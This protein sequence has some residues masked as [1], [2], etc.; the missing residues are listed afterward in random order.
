MSAIT[1]NNLV[2]QGQYDYDC[3]MQ[4]V[5]KKDAGGEVTLKDFGE[6]KNLA[7]G[8]DK[9]VIPPAEQNRATKEAVYK[10]ILARFGGEGSDD[11]YANPYIQTAFEFLLCGDDAPL[12]ADE[13]KCLDQLLNKGSAGKD[14]VKEGDVAND[15]KALRAL[16]WKSLDDGIQSAAK[17]LPKGDLTGEYVNALMEDLGKGFAEGIKPFL[18]E[19]PDNGSFADD[20]TADDLREDAAAYVADALLGSELGLKETLHGKGNLQVLVDAYDSNAKALQKALSAQ[21]N[22]KAR[23]LEFKAK[24]LGLIIGAAPKDDKPKPRVFNLVLDKMTKQC[25]AVEQVK[26]DKPKSE[27]VKLQVNVAQPKVN[28]VQQVNVAQQ[29]VKE[30]KPVK[31]DNPVNQVKSAP[32]VQVKD[33]LDLVNSEPMWQTGCSNCCWFFSAVNALKCMEGGLAHLKELVKDDRVVTFY[34]KDNVAHKYDLTKEDFGDA[35]FDVEEI[36]KW[37]DKGCTRLE[38]CVMC[39]AKKYGPKADYKI[40]DSGDMESACKMLGLKGANSGEALDKN[41]ELGDVRQL[42]KERLVKKQVVT[43]NAGGGHF[44]SIVGIDDDKVTI[45][46]SYKGEQNQKK[47][48]RQT[49]SLSYLLELC[50]KNGIDKASSLY[51]MMLPKTMEKGIMRIKEKTATI[52]KDEALSFLR[53]RKN[54]YE[55]SY[56]EYATGARGKDLISTELEKA[57]TEVAKKSKL[58]E[59][60]IEKVAREEN[61]FADL[62]KEFLT[63][64]DT[65]KGQQDA[66]AWIVNGH[67]DTD[68]VIYIA[69]PRDFGE[70]VLEDYYSKE[71]DS[72]KLSDDTV[73]LI[74][75][76]VKN[77]EPDDEKL[78]IKQ[79]KNKV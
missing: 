74:A 1:N 30:E 27:V 66:G 20:V 75:A 48:I 65:P 79:K 47:D 12:K 64:L 60:L 58:A 44:I 5:G 62:Q 37:S 17:K 26:V 23:V 35:E 34:D 28:V 18:K 68:S 78:M 72:V 16:K 54:S 73:S 43:F 46:D 22:A 51:F 3:L 41:S 31:V 40:G 38:L 61:G 10:A 52:N 21:D 56:E 49:V 71:K 11:K 19:G 53:E 36:T 67:V 42:I 6:V 29:P 63:I 55:Q 69:L 76:C 32:K 24:V 15:T 8:G 70:T 39:H 25:K 77:R 9:G 14:G 50:R 2:G 57:M 45:C 13:M 4:A 33:L 59:K 7:E